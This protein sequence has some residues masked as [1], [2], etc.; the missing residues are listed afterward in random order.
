MKM[1]VKEVTQPVHAADGTVTFRPGQQ[2]GQSE[3]LPEGVPWRYAITDAP[4][5]PPDAPPAERRRTLKD[6]LE[7]PPAGS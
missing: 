4:E 3:R 1:V 7:D 5:P 2:F 6:L